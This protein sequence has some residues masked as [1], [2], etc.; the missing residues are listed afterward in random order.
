MIF[1]PLIH[2]KMPTIVGILTYLSG[3]NYMLNWDEHEKGFITSG[4]GQRT[5]NLLGK[6]ISEV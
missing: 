6:F 3:E 1:F 2:V 5:G 4:P